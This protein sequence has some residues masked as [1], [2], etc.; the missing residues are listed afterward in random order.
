M[1]SRGEQQPELQ[2]DGFAPADGLEAWREQR[3]AMAKRVGQELGL[4]LDREVEVWLVG[5]VRLR[6]CLKLREEVLFV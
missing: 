5:G 3:R 4:P 6:G 2:F 1:Q